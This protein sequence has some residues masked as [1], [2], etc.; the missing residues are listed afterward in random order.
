M[1]G[2]Y[3]ET[4]SIPSQVLGVCQNKIGVFDQ[5]ILYA[6]SDTSYGML[7]KSM[8]PGSKARLITFTRGASGSGYYGRYDISIDDDA[9][10]NFSISN[11]VYVYSNIG[12]GQA[13]QPV[14]WQGLQTFSL[15]GITCALFLAIV[16]KGVLF[17][18]ARR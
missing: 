12:Y 4:T 6:L 1:N 13:L 18:C 3:T 16:F 10:W 14:C 2:Q 7:C 11:E 8:L 5:Y 9:A 17:R 15:V